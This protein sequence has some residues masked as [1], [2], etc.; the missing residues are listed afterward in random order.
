MVSDYLRTNECL[1]AM[2][3]VLDEY[4]IPW[5]A[6]HHGRH[7]KLICEVGGR[8]L[9]TAFPLTPSDHRS[10]AN[11]AAS[12]RRRI[13]AAMP[14][15]ETVSYL[16]V[17][18]MIE[19][20]QIEVLDEEPRI[21]DTDLAERLGMSRPR[22]IRSNLI[23]PNIEEFQALGN[24]RSLNAN[25]GKRGRPALSYYL[26]EEQALLAC[27]L[28][29][30]P[31]APAVRRVLIETFVAWRRGHLIPTPE[32]AQSGN[33]D[34]LLMGEEARRAIV[35]GFRCVMEEALS[36][37]H[38]TLCK[39]SSGRDQ[40]LR[41]DLN[42]LVEASKRGVIA[43]LRP[44]ALPKPDEEEIA[45]DGVYQMAGV[46]AI[47]RRRQL[48]WLAGNSIDAF[49]RE[50]RVPLGCLKLRG[51]RIRVWPKAVVREWLDLSGNSLIRAHLER[52]APSVSPESTTEEIHG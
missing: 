4:G 52:C 27:V 6:S 19:P 2:R 39:W 46:E 30:S 16:T 7:P 15:S 18:A 28:S 33:P 44:K 13:E 31:N 35:D 41:D 17:P 24:L 21:L 42:A 43:A 48:S 1:Q 20:P 25:L 26:N 32:P 34:D 23:S 29:R 36:D 5:S 49:C 40:I 11:C 38:R 22:D 12:L 51:E 8:R 9:T 14:K 3:E 45:L 50:R 47:P 10:P 37:Y